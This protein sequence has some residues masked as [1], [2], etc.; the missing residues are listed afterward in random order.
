MSPG[1]LRELARHRLRP[2]H[3]QRLGAPN[4]GAALLLP[5]EPGVADATGDALRPGPPGAASLPPLSI[6]R[7]FRPSR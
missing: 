7:L 6:R 4:E 3:L 5:S 2:G 1:R